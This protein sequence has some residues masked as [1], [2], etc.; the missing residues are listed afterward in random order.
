MAK[1]AYLDNLINDRLPVT[2]NNRYLSTIWDTYGTNSYA[3]Y[4]NNTL[5]NF[6]NEKII[7]LA[8]DEYLTNLA[9]NQTVLN[10]DGPY[11][12]T[13]TL[14]KAYLP[15]K[16]QHEVD[17]G[18]LNSVNESIVAPPDYLPARITAVKG[19]IYSTPIPILFPS[20]FSRSIS[21][22]FAKENPVG[23]DKPIMAYSYTDGEDIPLEFDALADYLPSPYT[24][25]KQYVE[26]ILD[27]LR[28]RKSNNVVFEPTVIVEFADM[29]FKGV[30]TS[31]NVS[32]D[33]LYNYKS[34]VHARI[35]CQF[36]KLS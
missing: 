22:S 17:R 25:L 24:S 3:S 16:K 2:Y 20:S 1:S 33:N 13:I 6:T 35:S 29:S 8:S 34:F 18:K 12:S 36:T 21:A 7:A 28:P 30:C 4:L 9:T 5:D 32:Y 15:I 14:N 10:M 26:A 19:G 27:I 31:I 23:S 11:I